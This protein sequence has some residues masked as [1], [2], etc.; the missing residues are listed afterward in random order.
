MADQNHSP[1]LS[2]A[3]VGLAYPQGGLRLG[4]RKL[5]WVLQDINFDLY[6]GETL[7]IIGRNAAGKSTLVRLLAGILKPDRGTLIDRSNSVALLALQAGFVPYL[8]GRQNAILSGILLGLRRA[9]VEARME[10]I[11]DFSELGDFINEPLSTYSSGMRARLG[12]AV[13][14]QVDPD[15][16]LIDETL[17]V[18][19]EEFNAK[20]TRAMHERIHS[21]K[22][23]VLVSHVAGTIQQL[24]DRAVW[25]EEGVTRAQGPVPEV[26]DAYHREITSRRAQ[27]NAGIRVLA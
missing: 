10:A 3:G 24:C 19:D 12:F 14:Y 1:L 16:L 6:P 11:I 18:G 13:A 7:G 22:T 9:E 23:I 17:G 26:I 20:S 4:R 2:L 5:F 8:T 25:L 15:I 27:G 21:D